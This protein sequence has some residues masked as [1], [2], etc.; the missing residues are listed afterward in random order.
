MMFTPLENQLLICDWRNE[1]S[2]YSKFIIKPRLS[3]MTLFFF[4]FKLTLNSNSRTHGHPESSQ[5]SWTYFHVPL[6]GITTESKEH[7]R[8]I[9][10]AHLDESSTLLPFFRRML[11]PP[12]ILWHLVMR[13]GIRPLMN[14]WFSLRGLINCPSTHSQ[15]GPSPKGSILESGSVTSHHQPLPP[16]PSKSPGISRE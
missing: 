16:L 4:F 11:A 15:M 7:P 6:P 5:D 8:F 2:N 1:K 10:A 9:S 13:R 14:A 12:G 3:S